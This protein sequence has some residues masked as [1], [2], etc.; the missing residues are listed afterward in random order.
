M[1]QASWNHGD[2][3]SIHIWWMDDFKSPGLRVQ[4]PPWLRVRGVCVISTC[5]MGLNWA[6]AF[7]LELVCAL[8][9]TGIPICPDHCLGP[10]AG[11][12]RL[13]ARINGWNIN[14]Y[15]CQPSLI[16]LKK[17]LLILFQFHS[18]LITVSLWFISV[19]SKAAPH[20]GR[21]LWHAAQWFLFFHAVSP[22]MLHTAIRH[23]LPGFLSTD[24]QDAQ[25]EELLSAT[26]VFLLT[27]WY[28]LD[29]MQRDRHHIAVNSQEKAAW[30]GKY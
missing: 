15:I 16:W 30:K 9:W 11:W 2:D 10:C 27:P 6:L 22:F 13:L 7:L 8:R 5:C 12:N 28:L 26:S 4:I 24:Q 14:G 25:S 29:Q 21:G 18:C 20:K 1:A 17:C 3:L 23:S 19:S